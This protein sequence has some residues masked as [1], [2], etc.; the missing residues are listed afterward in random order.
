MESVAKQRREP[1]PQEKPRP[2]LDQA[3]QAVR[4]A[5]KRRPFFI[6]GAIAAAVLIGLGGYAVWNHGKES[7]DDAQIEADVVPIA[8]RIAGMIKH[9]AVVENQHVKEGVLLV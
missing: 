9:G 2:A 5:K 6:L 8:P 4:P 7:T 3:V 1:E